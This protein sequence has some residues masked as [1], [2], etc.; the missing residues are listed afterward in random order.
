VVIGLEALFLAALHVGDDVVGH[1]VGTLDCGFN[2][3]GNDLLFVQVPDHVSAE[4]NVGEIHRAHLIG[5]KDP[6]PFADHVALVIVETT[7][8][9]AVNSFGLAMEQLSLDTLPLVSG[10]LAVNSEPWIPQV[11]TKV[12]VLYTVPSERV[13]LFGSPCLTAAFRWTSTPFFLQ[14]FGCGFPRSSGR[15]GR[16]E[17]WAS[18]MTIFTSLASI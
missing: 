7:S 18:T 17:S 14:V 12:R 16:I 9:H 4:V 11:H 10:I 8:G 13:N 15:M 5:N 3:L 2:D 6:S 1:H